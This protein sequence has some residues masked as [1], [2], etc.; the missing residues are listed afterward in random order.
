[1]R[2]N[3]QL[4]RLSFVKYDNKKAKM[5]IRSQ[6]VS[7]QAVFYVRLAAAFPKLLLQNAALQRSWVGF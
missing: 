1:L 5:A 7:H 3:R 6:Q 4:K 2:S